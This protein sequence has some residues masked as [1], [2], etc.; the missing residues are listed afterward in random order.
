MPSRWNHSSREPR[1]AEKH[2]FLGIGGSGAHIVSH[3]GRCGTRS[4]ERIETM[5]ADFSGRADFLTIY[6]KEAHPEDEWQVD[7]NE[8][9]GICYLQPKTLDQ[10][11]TIANDFV[12][13]FDYQVH[14]VVDT[15]DNGAEAAFA[16]WP[17]RL[18]VIDES[19]LIAYKGG[20][21]PMN[22]DPDEL[23][24]WLDANLAPGG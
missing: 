5:A 17:E 7:S 10:R 20:V 13:R 24:A 21:G 4:L 19:G 23:E 11:L 1:Y 16:G 22:F 8:D 3:I 2:G 12:K 18:Y 6:I 9:Q 15:M 14:L